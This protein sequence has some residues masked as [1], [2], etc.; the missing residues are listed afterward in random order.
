MEASEKQMILFHGRVKAHP[1]NGKG[2]KVYYQNCST[3][4]VYGLSLIPLTH[5]TS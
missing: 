1:L 5:F 3:D 2:R 4:I